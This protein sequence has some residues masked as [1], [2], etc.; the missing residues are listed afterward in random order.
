MQSLS[1]FI[2]MLGT[3]P[4]VKKTSLI[5]YYENIIAYLEESQ[6]KPDVDE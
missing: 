3:I 5:N 6:A 1:T 4:E 2:R